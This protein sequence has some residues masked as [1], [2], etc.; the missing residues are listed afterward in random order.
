MDTTPVRRRRARTRE[1]LEGEFWLA[2]EVPTVPSPPASHTMYDE[3]RLKEG[4]FYADQ[5]L[6]NAIKGASPLVSHCMTM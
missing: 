6:R 1:L 4:L 2:V 3:Q 5:T